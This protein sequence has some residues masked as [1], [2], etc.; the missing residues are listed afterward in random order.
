M[1][2]EQLLAW[3]SG[4]VDEQ[5]RLKVEYLAAENRILRDQIPGRPRLTDSQRITL[6][7]IGKK[8]G[9]EALEGVACIVMPETILGWHRKLIAGKFDTSHRRKSRA[10]G[11]PP[12]AAAIVELVERLSRE[13]PTWGYLRVAGALAELG[14]TISHQS[15][16]NILEE[17]G[18][19]PA[20]SRERKTSWSDFIK[21]HTDC[22]LATDFF[23]TE[24]WTA[25]GLVTY[26]CL[27]F[28]HVGSRK[29]YAAG[30][31]R[32]PTDAWMR[33]AARNLTSSGCDLLA[34]CRYLVRD[35]DTKFSSA[36]DMILRSVG[37]EPL[38]LPPRSP[39]LN[40]FAERF[41][42]SIKA[43]CLD[44]MIFFGEA[45]LQHAVGQYVEHYHHE[46]THQGKGNRLLFSL[47]AFDST[48]RDGPIHCKKRL[49]GLLNF[50]YKEAA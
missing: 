6:A 18:I 20:P 23:T 15:I 17:Y 16:K 50:Y 48:T 41:V 31:T 10:V 13:N 4:K 5:L 29:V 30:I 46:R 26:Y 21:S 49:G 11:R 19:D 32:N 40:A 36:F 8:L 44:R 14:E 39:N 27:F 43:E 45:S 33:Q 7:T 22:L 12:V 34:K 28:I 42:K 47:H 35:R 1:G 3:V 9:R 25:F 24:V 37:I 38:V 2:W